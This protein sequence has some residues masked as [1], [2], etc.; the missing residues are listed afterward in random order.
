M[1]AGCRIVEPVVINDQ[2]CADPDDDKFLRAAL[3]GISKKIVSGD[4]HLHDV[5]GYAGIE[6]LGPAEFVERYLTEPLDTAEQHE[7]QGL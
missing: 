4:K 1:T 5:N 3:G 7:N 6:I 2:V